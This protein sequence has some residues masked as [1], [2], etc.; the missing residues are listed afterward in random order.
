M[1]NELIFKTGLHREILK[2]EEQI[3]DSLNKNKNVIINGK[4][5]YGKTFILKRITERLKSNKTYAIYLNSEKENIWSNFISQLLQFY[6]SSKN[7]TVF[8]KEILELTLININKQCKEELYKSFYY[9]RQ[10]IKDI[11]VYTKLIVMV[12]NIQYQN[13]NLL[14]LISFLL[15]EK[16][17]DGFNFVVA[18]SEDLDANF[19]S[20]I[21]K[22]KKTDFIEYSLKKINTKLIKEIYYEIFNNYDEI[23]VKKIF[24]ITDGNPLLVLQYL[25]YEKNNREETHINELWPIKTFNELE[26][27]EKNIIELICFFKNGVNSYVLTELTGYPLTKVEQ[28]IKKVYLLGLISYSITDI[29]LIFKVPYMVF[30]DFILE[31]MDNEYKSKIRTKIIN[32]LNKDQTYFLVFN[33]EVLFQINH[34]NDIKLK[35][36]YLN[37]LHRF[38]LNQKKW[39]ALIEIKSEL[40]KLHS[41]EDGFKIYESI[42]GIYELVGETNKAIEIYDNLLNQY[43]NN[44]YKTLDILIKKAKVFVRTNNVKDFKTIMHI[45]KEYKIEDINNKKLKDSVMILNTYNALFDGELETAKY[46]CN[47]ILKDKNTELILKGE[48]YQIFA[49]VDKFTGNPKGAIINF[50]KAYKLFTKCGYVRGIVH[51]LNNCG[52]I[53]VD[54]LKDFKMGLKYLK[55]S[56]EVARRNNV[57]SLEIMPICNMAFISFYRFNF[58]ECKKYCIEAIRYINRVNNLA[59]KNILLGC[60]SFIELWNGNFK[61]AMKYIKEQ[62]ELID[63]VHNSYLW[64]YNLSMAL[65]NLLI[66]NEI[67]FNNYLNKIRLNEDKLPINEEIELLFNVNNPQYFIDNIDNINPSLKLDICLQ[68]CEKGFDSYAMTIYKDIKLDEECNI[69]SIAKDYIVRYFLGYPLN[70]ENIESIIMSVK[71]KHILWKLYF[72][73]SILNNNNNNKFSAINDIMQAANIINNIFYALDFSYKNNYIKIYELYL[74]ELKRENLIEY[75]NFVLSE[76]NKHNRI[77]DDIIK[78]Y[79]IDENKNKGKVIFED[80]IQVVKEFSGDCVKNLELIINY[81]Q[82]MTMSQEVYIVDTSNNVIVSTNDKLKNR[83]IVKDLKEGIYKSYKYNINKKVTKMIIEIKNQEFNEAFLVVESDKYHNNINVD[84]FNQCKMLTNLLLYNIHQFNINQN[85]YID[86]LTGAYNRKYMDKVFEELDNFKNY[87][88]AMFDMDN[89]KYIN[90][91]FGH[92][93]GDKVLEEFSKVILT[94]KKRNYLLFRYGGE[95]FLLFMPDTSKEEALVFCEEVRK[96]IENKQIQGIDYK[97]TVSCGLY[98]CDNIK[99]SIN[100]AIEKADM[101]LYISKNTGKN[102]C[103]AWDAENNIKV[104]NEK[105]ISTGNIVKDLNY[106]NGMHKLINIVKMRLN[107]EQKVE[108]YKNIIKEITSAINVDIFIPSTKII[109]DNLFEYTLL[110]MIEDKSLKVFVETIK[111]NNSFFIKENVLVPIIKNEKIEYVLHIVFDNQNLL[112][113]QQDYNM[114]STIAQI[115]LLMV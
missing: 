94:T 69:D 57:T 37:K 115:Y 35:L 16:L 2:F 70:L 63:K 14:D 75:F 112:L 49:V 1:Q 38:Y 76:D 46:I 101:A 20:F 8:N 53:W 52:T 100:S 113:T 56:L 12:D 5:G 34:I 62:K 89:F 83:Q 102:K 55:R 31:K 92:L 33:D 110:K 109:K 27:K 104:N 4:R 39:N 87:S 72:I 18:Y 96:I 85:F 23:K 32:L 108:L 91:K 47:N 30:K 78:K 111:N 36:E 50:L 61:K 86:K 73:K 22:I 60:L 58:D 17:F 11:T 19:T 64:A 41:Y 24:E 77:N 48:A 25:N 45:I 106:L 84:S 28:I 21:E 107:K 105:S 65:F 15:K 95:E 59:I 67:E 93:L 43:K 3:I 71:N 88:I 6:T 103:T 79:W 42:S 97:L 51:S 114:L 90:D 98:F 82:C 68:L 7:Y 26:E 29:G 81:I 9:I 74:K 54:D 44:S 10:I 13:E 40:M 99:E 80:I 66:N